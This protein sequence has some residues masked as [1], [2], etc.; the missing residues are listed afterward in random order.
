M[1]LVD[2]RGFADAGIAGDQNQL[3]RAT[4]DDAIEGGEQG[5]DLARSAV[6][7]LGNQ[8]PVGRVVL[9][10]GEVVDAAVSLPIGE[11]ALQVALQ[12]GGGLVALLGRLGEQLHDDLGNGGRDGLQ[13]L[14]GRQ[15]LPGDMAVDPFHRIGRH[16]RQRACEH[17]IEGNAERIKIAARVDRAVHPS[18]LLGRHIGQRAGDGFGRLERLSFAGKPR[19]D[20]EAGKPAPV[21]RRS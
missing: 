19:G 10:Q 12:A 17:L 13:P 21:R 6:Q 11:A 8:Q 4:L 18:G 5:L 15:R 14:A 1:Q 7:L 9:A 16:E 2:D 20:A 3:R